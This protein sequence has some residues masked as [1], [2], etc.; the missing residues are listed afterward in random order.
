MTPLRYCGPKTNIV[1]NG[2]YLVSLVFRQGVVGAPA[3]EKLRIAV[4]NH[5][6]GIYGQNKHA[7]ALLRQILGLERVARGLRGL[8]QPLS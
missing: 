5:N 2:H 3:R 1:P 8:T 6:A 7:Y 4:Y